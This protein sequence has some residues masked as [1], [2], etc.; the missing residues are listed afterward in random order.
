MQ[1][2]DGTDAERQVRV[3]YRRILLVAGAFLN[4]YADLAIAKLMK[5]SRGR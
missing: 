2:V 3:N 5:R 4:D 1:I